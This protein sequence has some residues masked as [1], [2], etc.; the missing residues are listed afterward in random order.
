LRAKFGSRAD[1]AS[2]QMLIGKPFEDD[3]DELFN[4]RFGERQIAGYNRYL[5]SHFFDVDWHVCLT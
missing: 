2:V 4:L 1:P 5:V 3:L